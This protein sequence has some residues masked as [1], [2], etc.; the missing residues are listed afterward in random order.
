MGPRTTTRQAIPPE[1]LTLKS[2]RDAIPKHYFEPNAAL[3]IYYIC[4]DLF[5]MVVTFAIMF[6]Y[7]MPFVDKQMETLGA[8]NYFLAL[9]LKFAVWNVYWYVQGLNCTGLWVMAHEC[10]HR[11]CSSSKMVNDCLGMVIHSILLVPYHSW[12]ITHGT[13]HKYTNHVDQ[14]TVFV[15]EK[16][17]AQSAAIREALSETPIASWVN[18]IKMWT[19][20]WPM[21]LFFNY[22]GQQHNR[23]ANHFEPSSPLFRP[24]EGGV[25]LLSDLGLMAVLGLAYALV[26]K[27]LITP[28]DILIWYFVPYL[29]ANSW[30]VTITY[31]HHTDLRVPHYNADN[32]NFV[33]GALACVDRDYGVIRN[34]MFHYINNSHVIHHLFSAMPFFHAIEVTD[35]YL[36]K[37]VP[38]E[39]HITDD[40]SV[41][42]MCFESWRECRY[43]VPSEGISWFRK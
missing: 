29:W 28:Y 37:A 34:W 4:R 6:Y 5:Q 12:R 19:L 1:S 39:M 3:S 35:K 40:R 25:V 27:G 17:S 30:L 10:G 9:G 14:D 41:L 8:D 42:S 43:I 11:A 15:P 7:G 16:V 32:W 13:H 18:I 36:P 22:T 20:G 33:R 23:R 2:I 21:H 26:H 31:L 24:S 38:E